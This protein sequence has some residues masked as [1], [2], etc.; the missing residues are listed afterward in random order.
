MIPHAV[1]SIDRPAL[2]WFVA[3]L[4]RYRGQ[5]VVVSLAAV[6][7]SALTIP[8]LTLVRR[9]LDDVLPAR[10]IAALWWIGAALLFLRVAGSALA[11]WVRAVV[12]RIVKNA[13]RDLRDELSTHILGRGSAFF[14][15]A[16]L[17][18]LHTRL[19]QDTERV[20]N[21]T[22]TLIAG[23]LPALV[24]SVLLLTI[25][26]RISPVLVLFLGLAA[27]ALWGAGRLTSRS[28][29]TELDAFRA[30]F[31]EYSGG[32]QFMLRFMDLLRMRA[33]QPAETRA[34]HARH[35]AL[36]DAGVD[37]GMS[38]AWHAHS[39][40]AITTIAG[41]GMLM[42]GGAAVA[43]GEMTLGQFF[44]FYVA[45]GMMSGNV[46]TV[47][48]S[49]PDLIAG[50]TALGVLRGIATSGE[51]E[52][53]AGTTALPFAGGVALQDVVFSYGERPLLQGVTLDIAP[54]S[55]VAI[56][57]ENGAGKSTILQLLLGTLRPHGGQVL[58]DGMPY[59]GRDVPHLRRQMGVVP[60]HPLFFHGTILDNLR[61][62]H[63]SVD[64]AALTEALAISAA[65]AVI[66]RLPD[67]LSTIIGDR[68]TRL[69]GGE[70]QRLSIARALLHRP[71]LLMLDEPTTHLD[72]Q[73]I[74]HIL[75]ELAAWAHHPAIVLISHDPAISAFASEG[76][77]LTQGRL[78]PIC[79]P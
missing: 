61:F 34:Q 24:T 15:Q 60:Q 8:T 45:A 25:M 4:A 74:A 29:K 39:Q 11:L 18:Q 56:V 17:T 65:D 5:L 2:R 13:T 22:T 10:D 76:W 12:L 55:H 37:M 59:D 70:S 54:G 50:S 32:T 47:I 21:V 52:P 14:S 66:A 9:A 62:G 57:G 51:G 35:L 23:M 41:L 72:T 78:V 27:P 68:G 26:V 46:D 36:A 63:E 44:V 58:A 48:G 42:L 71:A 69:S 33:W 30:R 64:P 77:H 38:Y 79:P 16:D 40:R 6:M 73:S 3:R 67:G 43:R 31:E 1:H 53:Y 7:Q 19:V 28:I 20:D 75:R 49:V